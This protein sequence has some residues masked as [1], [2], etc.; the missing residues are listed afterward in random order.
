MARKKTVFLR[1]IE[2]EISR[3]Y[4]E[5]GVGGITIREISSRLNIAKASVSNGAGSKDSMI[6]NYVSRRLLVAGHILKRQIREG[7]CPQQ[8]IAELQKQREDSLLFRE[9]IPA[10]E[11]VWTE[12]CSK[13]LGGMLRELIASLDS[14]LNRGAPSVDT[15]TVIGYLACRAHNLFTGKNA[16]RIHNALSTQSLSIDCG[17]IGFNLSTSSIGSQ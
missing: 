12:N 10:V 11:I 8:A 2:R 4:L 9:L 5:E 16:H 14:Y 7:K 3:I 6:D 17:N 13:Q 15:L 1:D